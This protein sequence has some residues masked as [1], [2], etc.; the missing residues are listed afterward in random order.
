MTSRRRLPRKTV[1]PIQANA[2]LQQWI[3]ETA[4]TLHHAGWRPAQVGTA[5]HT[6]MYE[7]AALGLTRDL[8]A[9]SQLEE[10]PASKTGQY[11]FESQ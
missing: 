7:L 5:Y 6:T 3:K 1:D 8:A 11:G 10:E 4:T 2:E 9:V